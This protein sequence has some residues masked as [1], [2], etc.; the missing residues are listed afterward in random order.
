MAAFACASA[1]ALASEAAFA[2]A[3]AIAFASAATFDSASVISFASA[4]EAAFAACAACALQKFSDISKAWST[5]SLVVNC[6]W[7]TSSWR[8]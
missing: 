1:I 5:A 7:C 6:R 8:A 2:S 3:S 4:S